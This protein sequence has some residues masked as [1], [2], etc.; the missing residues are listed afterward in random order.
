MGM[1]GPLWDDGAKGWMCGVARL[2]VHG[3][4]TCDVSV[5]SGGWMGAGAVDR[6]G[7][8]GGMGMVDWGTGGAQ[9]VGW[10]GGRGWLLGWGWCRWL[11]RWSEGDCR[12]GE[13]VSGC[14]LRGGGGNDR[15]HGQP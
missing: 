15:S 8:G 3:E 5:G 11:V 10:T 12:R 1:V 14:G 7:K 2:V 4:W 13:L 9:V 6:L